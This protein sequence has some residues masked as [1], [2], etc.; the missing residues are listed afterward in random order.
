M[1][2]KSLA[3]LCVTGV[4][5]A[6]LAS[7]SFAYA[8]HSRRSEEQTQAQPITGTP[9][10][11]VIAL[12]QQRVSIYGAS[13]KLMEA[14]VSTGTT[15]HETPAGTYTILQKEEEHHSNLYDDAS[16]PYMERLTWTGMAI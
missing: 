5:A 1:R 16:M 6:D 11:A 3:V 15:G 4:T 10:L 2:W 8:R 13:G 12:A 7:A 9:R 14:P